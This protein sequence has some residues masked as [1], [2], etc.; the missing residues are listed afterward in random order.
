S[1]ASGIAADYLEAAEPGTCARELDIELT[2]HAP[3]YM[4]FADVDGLAAKSMD[5][6]VWGGLLADALQARYV[7]VHLGRYGDLDR[8]LAL[9][10]VKDNLA[11]V[12]E[13]YKIARL[14]PGLGVEASGLQEVV[15]GLDELLWLAKQ[16]KGVVPVLNFAHIHAR[17]SGTLRRPEGFITAFEKKE[18][19]VDVHS[20]RHFSGVEH[21]G[22][23]E[24]RYTPIKKG[25][26]RFEPLAE[27]LLDRP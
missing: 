7:V 27:S 24:V 4:D 3:Y 5:S 2:L 12:R 15:G 18:K 17:E 9:E 8:Q 10:R 20:H 14:S 16:V 1:L 6:A 23:N 26:L 21:E 25:D 13:R 19:V 22:G 11:A